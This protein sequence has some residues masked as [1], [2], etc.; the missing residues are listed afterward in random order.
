MDT[1]HDALGIM[2]TNAGSVEV[3]KNTA[4]TYANSATTALT[5]DTQ[6]YGVLIRTSATNL[7]LKFYTNSARTTQHGSTVDLTLSSGITGLNT[8]QHRTTDNGGTSSGTSNIIDNVKVYNGVTSA[9]NV[10]S[11][12][13]T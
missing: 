5:V 6:Y 11:E 13:G 4:G 8:I 1:S 10:W 7:R 9:G 12:E 3:W 2:A